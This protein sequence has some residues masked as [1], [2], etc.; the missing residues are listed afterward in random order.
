MFPTIY[1]TL[2]PLALAAYVTKAYSLQQL[3]C[4]LLL[5]GVGDTYLLTTSSDKYV[6]R[7]YRSDHRSLDN[8][9]A[10]VALLN[11]LKDAGV[12]VSYPISD[13]SGVFIQTFD[14]AEGPRHAV[15]FSYAPGESLAKLSDHQLRTLGASIAK[16]HQASWHAT[17]P[18]KR[19][20]YSIDATLVQPVTMA[21]PWLEALPDE[22]SW[23]KDATQH[24]A[25]ELHSLNVDKFSKGYCHYDFLPK[26]FHFHDDHITMFDFDFLG[27]G[28]LIND[29]MTFWNHLSL[30]VQFNRMALNEARRSFDVMLT[31]Y[32]S[33]RS[34]TS[35][36]LQAIPHLSLSWWCYYMGFHTTHDQFTALVQPAHLKMRTALIR[37]VTE[38]NN[39]ISFS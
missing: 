18:G 26:N 27:T 21:T 20:D 24:A 28:W 9:R 4:R 10:E 17:L 25:E 19:W 7:V 11:I 37:Q 39:T 8:I 23:W 30:D 16:F 32:T 5:R 1:S 29:L 14:A 3:S 31:S 15:L 38:R 22:L 36:E 2:D 12:P 6:L 34:V 35:T 13:K 33:I